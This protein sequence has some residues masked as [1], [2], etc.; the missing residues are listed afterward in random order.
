M[1]P[2]VALNLL[3]LL[4][5]A[6]IVARQG[7]NPAA[8]AQRAMEEAAQQLLDC[9]DAAPR[10][11]LQLLFDSAERRDWH[12]VPRERL[13]VPLGEM[14]DAQ[15]RCAHALLR[16]ALSSRGYLKAAGVMQL[17]RVLHDLEAA[18]GRDASMRDPG[19]YSITVRHARA[20]DHP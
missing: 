18:G 19:R 4:V 2:R 8:H 9:F 16:S 10:A 6:G 13:G 5:L 3:T 15:R 1:S 14:N 11:R 20:A 17:E 7:E 12:Y